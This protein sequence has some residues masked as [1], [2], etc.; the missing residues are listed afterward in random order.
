MFRIGRLLSIL[1]ECSFLNQQFNKFR[2]IREEVEIGPDGE[3]DTFKRVS[4]TLVTDFQSLPEQDHRAIDGREKEFT[5]AG[6][7]TINRPFPNSELICESLRIGVVV[8]VLSK[9]MRGGDQDLIPTPRPV[10]ITVIRSLLVR[11]VQSKLLK[12]DGPVSPGDSRRHSA[13]G[14][15]GFV[16]TRQIFEISL[17]GSLWEGLGDHESRVDSLSREIDRCARQRKPHL[18][19]LG[20]TFVIL[21]SR[22]NQASNALTTCAGS[23]PVNF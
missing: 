8:T 19:M 10:P 1:E 18:L 21:M 23:T 11:R 5:L 6:K 3:P 9:Q 13:R 20:P 17:N 16:M 7:A 2:V 14:Q 4:I 15:R 12:P 22:I